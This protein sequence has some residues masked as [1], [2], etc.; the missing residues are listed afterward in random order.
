MTFLQQRGERAMA[1][2]RLGLHVSSILVR[3]R[4]LNVFGIQYRVKETLDVNSR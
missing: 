3:L 2:V 1:R 4:K